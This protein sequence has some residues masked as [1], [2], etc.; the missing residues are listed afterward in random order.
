MLRLIL[1]SLIKVAADEEQ[2]D[3]CDNHLLF[4]KVSG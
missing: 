4:G 2:E 3:E 1:N